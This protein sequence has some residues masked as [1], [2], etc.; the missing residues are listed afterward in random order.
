M[1]WRNDGAAMEDVLEFGIEGVSHGGGGGFEGRVLRGRGRKGVTRP[2]EERYHAE[3]RRHG[4]RRAEDQGGKEDAK[5]FGSA[6][7]CSALP[8]GRR[9]SLPFFFP[10]LS[11][12]A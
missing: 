4:E 3:T 7:A 11:F 2:G 12:S 1:G 9:L 6:Y 5:V 10:L 8:L